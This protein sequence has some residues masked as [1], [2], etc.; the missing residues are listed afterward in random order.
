MLKLK[1]V[2]ALVNGELVGNPEQ[3]IHRVVGIEEAGE[4]D[5]TFLSNPRYQ[6]LLASTHASA[7][8]VPSGTEVPGK[9]LIQ[10]RNPYLAFAQ[11]LEAFTPKSSPLPGIHEKAYLGADVRLGEEVALFPFCFIGNRVVLGDRVVIYPGVSIGEGSVIGEDTILYSNVTLY[12]GTEIGKRVIIHAGT[13]VGSDGFGFVQE[14]GRNMKV[15]QIGTVV[16]ED[17]VEIGSNVSIDRATMGVTVIRRGV[18]IDNLVQVAHNVEIGEDSVVI[19]QVGISGSTNIGKNV[20]LGGQVG[21]V[22]HIKVGDRAKVAAKTGVS[23][24]IPP[25]TIIAGHAGVPFKQWK[26]SVAALRR[27]PDTTKKIHELEKRLAELERKLKKD[28]E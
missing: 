7:I 25:D 9:A 27:L 8:I 5:I 10:A 17:D 11:V 12:P 16:I 14:D 1:E 3:E 24:S 26:R 23:K 19:S 18:K 28:E 15:P 20:M 21:I 13:V 4:G 6:S 22:G 2:A